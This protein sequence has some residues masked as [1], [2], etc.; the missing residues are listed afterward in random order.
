MD[1]GQLEMLSLLEKLD[2]VM[3]DG[4]SGEILD[5]ELIKK[6]RVQGDRDGDAQEARGV[7]ESYR[8]GVLDYRQEAKPIGVKWVDVNKGM[9]NT[10]SIGPD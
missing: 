1:V 6:A 10:Q 4:S 7:R 9:R 2:G 3:R 8:G 5:E